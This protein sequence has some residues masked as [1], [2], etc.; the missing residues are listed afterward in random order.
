M[1]FMNHYLNPIFAYTLVIFAATGYILSSLFATTI[2]VWDIVLVISVIISASIVLLSVSPEE[3]QSDTPS[4]LQSIIGLLPYVIFIPAIWILLSNPELQIAQH[5]D[6]HSGFVNQILY[7]HGQP[8]NVYVPGLPANYYW[9]YHALIASLSHIMQLPHPTVAILLNIAVLISLTGWVHRILLLVLPE[10]YS[11]IFHSM[12]VIFVI[13]GM[14]LFGSLQSMT[15]FWDNFR[16]WKIWEIIEP[17]SFAEPRLNQLIQKFASYTSFPAS[18]LFAWISIYGGIKITTQ[19]ASLFDISLFLI[20]ISGATAFMLIGGAIM[21]GTIF[22]A[23]IATWLY[24]YLRKKKNYR[25]IIGNFDFSNRRGGVSIGISIVA[26][27]ILVIYAFIALTAFADASETGHRVGFITIQSFNN[28]TAI[29]AALYALTLFV[30]IALIIIW[31][32]SDAILLFLLFAATT[33]LYG[34]L[35]IES[36]EYYKLIIFGACFV[37]LIVARAL[38]GIEIR[39]SEQDKSVQLNTVL[40]VILYLLVTLNILSFSWGRLTINNTAWIEVRAFSYDGT[41]VVQIDDPYMDVYE[42]IRDETDPETIIII[43]PDT[44]AYIAMI[45]QRLPLVSDVYF[46]QAF[47]SLPEWGNRTT[48]IYQIVNREVQSPEWQ[49]AWEQLQAHL[50]DSKSYVYVFTD[51]DTPTQNELIEAGLE[52]VFDG[53]NADVYRYSQP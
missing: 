26:L 33:V 15:D 7:G 25:D 5:G 34:A 13:F 51:N 41:A 19:K 43:K 35:T 2:I 9:L 29:F 46:S 52:L 36:S 18:Y 48:W 12:L 22:S 37:T 20:G 4:I 14:N 28:A 42:W 21:L 24:L 23:I 49:S 11:P 53:Q 39:L 27:V 30:I 3:T 6:L 16:I 40:I 10:Q 1:R 47:S 32:E 45:T 38:T 31:H 44:S 17:V 50:D 8:E